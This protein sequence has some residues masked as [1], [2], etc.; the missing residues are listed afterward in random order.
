[1]A[2]S[3]GADSVRLLLCA[4]ETHPP[5]GVVALHVNHGARGD[6]SEGDQRFV[7]ALCRSLSVP[8]RVA[9]LSLPPFSRG[10]GG[11][12]FEERAR[13]ERYR[14]LESLARE[15]RLDRVLLGHTADDQAETV[16]MRILEGGGVSGLKGIPASRGSLFYR[17]LS[18]TERRTIEADLD[19]AGVPY[20][21]DSS[22]RDLSFERNWVRHV[23]LPL[24]SSRYGPSA[25]RRLRVLAER[26]RQVDDY[27][28]LQAR[29][30]VLACRAPLP[31]EGEGS[32]AAA[33]EIDRDA[34]RK[35]PALLRIRV[36][37]EVF[38]SL[39]GREP[40]ERA[41]EQAERLVVEGPP[42]AAADAGSG[43]VVRNVYGKARFF[44]A[45]S[46]REGGTGKA[47]GGEVPEAA[48]E[49][50]AVPLPLPG[51][52]RW[53]GV[54]PVTVR[55]RFAEGG[56][57]APPGEGEP[58]FDLDRLRLPLGLAPVRRGDRIALPGGTG[59]KKVQDL[60]TDAKVPRGSRWGRCAVV[61]GTGAIL[62][63]PGVARSGIG[64]PSPPAIRL[65]VLGASFGSDVIK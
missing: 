38:R 65:V 8:L 60:F 63:I 41:L 16:L 35:L 46:W 45:A 1:V 64:R 5:E 9:R 7:E 13:R 55:A 30:W 56:A 51:S 52:A 61:D 19:A 32:G 59:T 54:V 4:L 39:G 14:A 58:L 57:E 33:L 21:T 6:E 49:G 26:F 24:V 3:G 28:A 18:G 43:R 17:P 36:L 11:A 47:T 53:E 12:G 40:S 10:G 2:L 42:S 20:R 34:F 31:G 50:T 27:L 29:D 15:E 44:R 22:N 62:W 48:G 37:Q 23:L 25:T